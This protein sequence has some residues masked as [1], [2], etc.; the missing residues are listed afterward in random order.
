[1]PDGFHLWAKTSS[2][3]IDMIRHNH[4]TFVSFD[5][6]SGDGDDFIRVANFFEKR[7]LDHTYHQVEWTIHSANPIG[8]AA[9]KAAMEQADKFWE[10]HLEEQDRKYDEMPL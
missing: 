4:I 6:D 7:A 1:M 2:E 3:A 5:H 9:I 8:R 10:I